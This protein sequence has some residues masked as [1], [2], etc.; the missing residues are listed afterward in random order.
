MSLLALVYNESIITEVYFISKLYL[1]STNSVQSGL[2]LKVVSVSTFK[3]V[4]L[5]PVVRQR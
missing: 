1:K 2:G 5:P 4:A 3:G